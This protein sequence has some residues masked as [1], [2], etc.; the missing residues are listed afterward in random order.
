MKTIKLCFY[1]SI[2]LLLLAGV[3]KAA[4]ELPDLPPYQLPTFDGQDK[5]HQDKAYIPPL[6]PAPV[7]NADR[8]FET[9]I[10][11]YPAP[12]FWRIDVDLVSR[13]NSSSSTSLDDS[14]TLSS[15]DKYYIG[16]V[17]RMPLYSR[18]EMDRARDR[19]Y[20]R[21]QDVAKHVANFVLAIADRNNARRK[22]GL[23][24]SLEARSQARVLDGITTTTE[25]AGYMEKVINAQEQLVNARAKITEARLHLV[26]QCQDQHTAQ[27]NNYLK[28]VT[29]QSEL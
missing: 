8:L 19:E 1:S 22:L 26:G 25:Q 3:S 9:V 12:S 29:Q 24:K 18:T 10:N 28:D 20:K 23:Y 4:E 27:V 11:C 7:I 16:I 17:A 14:G 5:S 6:V 21:R 2:I 13:V 15:Q